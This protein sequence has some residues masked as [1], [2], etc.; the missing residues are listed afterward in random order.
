MI[1]DFVLFLILGQIEL[2]QNV[3]H[4]DEDGEDDDDEDDIATM[5][6]I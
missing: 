4:D 5:M 2:S 1:L 6:L 3:S